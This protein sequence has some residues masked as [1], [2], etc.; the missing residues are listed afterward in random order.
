MP[1]AEMSHL[2]GESLE[3]VLYGTH[4]RGSRPKR[5]PARLCVSLI[6]QLWHFLYPLKTPI[7][8]LWRS[9]RFCF[10][11][12]DRRCNSFGRK[13]KTTM[14]SFRLCLFFSCI[15]FQRNPSFSCWS[16]VSSHVFLVGCPLTHSHLSP[17]SAVL[18]IFF[19]HFSRISCE[20]RER[21]WSFQFPIW[22]LKSRSS[23]PSAPLR[24]LFFFLWP[25]ISDLGRK[26][27]RLT[28]WL[29][30]IFLFFFP[31]FLILPS[32]AF[33]FLGGYIFCVEKYF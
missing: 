14:D 20:R 2:S 12:L 33:L 22:P 10:S 17:K 24:F 23:Y 32:F 16:C 5:C 31:K 3:I 11:Q 15:L 7:L 26:E 6:F 30:E 8:P 13:T 1:R 27:I 9:L 4:L 28:G 29:S 25:E 19:L 21:R 18:S